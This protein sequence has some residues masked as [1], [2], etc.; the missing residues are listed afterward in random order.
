MK[1]VD[2]VFKVLNIMR[3]YLKIRM[4]IFVINLGFVGYFVVEP[5]FGQYAKYL[6]S[7]WVI[8]FRTIFTM[9]EAAFAISIYTFGIVSLN[10]FKELLDFPKEL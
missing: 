8:F 10:R 4:I 5:N 6:Y 3:V 1:R 9:G 2:K 7:I